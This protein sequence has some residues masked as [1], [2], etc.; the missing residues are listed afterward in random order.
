MGAVGCAALRRT[1]RAP[2]RSAP[3]FSERAARDFMGAGVRIMPAL[4]AL[5]L[6]PHALRLRRLHNGVMQT[7]AAGNSLRIGRPRWPARRPRG[8]S[9]ELLENVDV[10]A[11]MHA[12]DGPKLHVTVDGDGAITTLRN[13][14]IAGE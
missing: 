10:L 3:A 7:W 14:R 8:G 6:G 5:A 1:G 12:V 13:G 11:R 9:L 4:C 2:L